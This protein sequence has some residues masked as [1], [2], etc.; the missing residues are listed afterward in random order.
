M[1]KYKHLFAVFLAKQTSIIPVFRVAIMP[2]LIGIVFEIT[3]TKLDY[4]SL[5]EYVWD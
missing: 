2:E 3:S 5:N 4:S 1:E